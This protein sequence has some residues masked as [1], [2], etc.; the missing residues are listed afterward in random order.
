MTPAQKT[1]RTLLDRQSTERGR[2]AEIAAL[3]PAK[4]TDEV[5]SEAQTLQAGTSDLEM[6]I[7]SARA[8]VDGDEDRSVNRDNHGKP[9]DAEEREKI[10]LRS[11]ISVGKFLSAGMQGQR[12]DGAEE[13]YRQAVGAKE[14]TIPIDAFE[15]DRP[16]ETRADA[17]TA[18]PGTIG[19][20]MREIVPIVFSKSLAMSLGIAMP[21]AAPGQYS[22][23]RLT[24]DLTAAAV[25]KG[26]DQ[27][28]TAGAFTVI[29]AKPRRLS[30]RLSLRAEDLAEAGI[31]SFEGSLRQAL[32]LKL[33]EVLDNQIINGNGTSPNISGLFTE[34]DDATAA[35]VVVTFGSFISTMAG[36]VDGKWARK[37]SDLRFF[38]NDTVYQA[39]C[40]TFQQPVFVNKGTG[41][42][43]N[44]SG[45]GSQSVYSS[46]DWAAE[47]LA[48]YMV[49]DRM[50]A[51][52]SGVSTCLA[53]RAGGMLD[54]AG[55]ASMP[56]VLPVWGD[57]G[58]SDPFSDSGSATEHYTL[59]TLIGDK[60]LVRQPDVYSEVSLK[61]S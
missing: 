8:A 35:T 26:T 21:R 45:V 6:Q 61:S 39:L 32:M 33:G 50:P 44:A 9:I 56:S 2:L 7:R 11:R 42:N 51:A 15:L 47:K 10:E 16:I 55:E 12:V 57:I 37:L 59:H 31:P 23:P 3:D 34:L 18:A 30:A 20:N 25:A 49:H 28:S 27:E 52:A 19:I 36:L 54:P 38:S 13:E 46:A 14:R 5:R 41:G 60:V 1:L 4:I 40:A 22:I 17:A 43:A 58:I 24:T 48:G 29:S 53:M